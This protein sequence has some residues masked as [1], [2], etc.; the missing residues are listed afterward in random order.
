MELFNSIWRLFYVLV[1]SDSRFARL[2]VE[3][4]ETILCHA[5]AGA[6]YNWPNHI[7]IV[8]DRLKRVYPDWGI[9]LN[10]PQNRRFLPKIHINHPDLL[11]KKGILPNG[12]R[13][14]SVKYLMKHFGRGSGLLREIQRIINSPSNW[15]NAWLLLFAVVFQNYIIEMIYWNDKK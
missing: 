8:Y 12:G 1:F 5:L 3:V 4:V 9:I 14:V 13:T 11:P 2:P 7:V 10:S 6:N 15:H